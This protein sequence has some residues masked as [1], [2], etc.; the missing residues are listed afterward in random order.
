DI[1]T[2]QLIDYDL[3]VFRSALSNKNLQTKQHQ[4]EGVKWC[5]RN[6]TIGN[7]I[8][9]KNIQGG[10]VADEMGLGKTIQMV[11]V[12]LSNFLLHTLIIVPKAILEQWEQEIFKLTNHNA[13]IYH[14]HNKK[15]PEKL[16]SSPIILTTYGMIQ[17]H[18]SELFKIKWSRV[19]FD[20]AHH[21][22]NKNTKI[23]IGALQL[24]A[25][26]KW[27]ITGT[28][29]QNTKTDFYNIC[30]VIGVDMQKTL[31]QTGFDNFKDIYLKRTK[32]E[33]GLELS[34]VKCNTININWLNNSEKKLS[35]KIHSFTQFSLPKK[36]Q[37]KEQRQAQ[38]LQA[39]QLQA[40]QSQHASKYKQSRY[41]QSRYKSKT[42]QKRYSN[43]LLKMSQKH[44]H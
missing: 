8:G 17:N 2:K 3:Q 28:P 24:N 32:K 20:E 4:I 33:I 39:Q 41:N 16:A 13:F 22:K 37:T 29:I 12:I 38:Q 31:K 23:F 26:I 40:Q 30:S 34:D 6:E 27:A 10:I 11:G 36:Y 18:K 44:S 1:E 7:V 43:S 15:H 14:R 19:V 25:D 9:N 42:L 35:E 21:L 5:M